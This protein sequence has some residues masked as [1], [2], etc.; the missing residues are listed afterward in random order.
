MTIAALRPPALAIYSCIS[1]FFSCPTQAVA[2]LPEPD[3]TVAAVAWS[4]ALQ[5]YHEY[6]KPETRLYK[7]KQYVE[8]AY[9][10]KIGHP[11]FNDDHFQKGSVFYDGVQYGDLDL[12]YDLVKGEVVI[13]DPFN[14]YKIALINERLDRFTILNH[15]FIQLSG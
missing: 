5:F 11:Y 1:F 14:T 7:G 13:K 8:Y 9:T 3:S 2:Q 4:G 6:L 15:S 12:L 10:I